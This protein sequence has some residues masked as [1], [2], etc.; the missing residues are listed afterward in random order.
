MG[1]SY[2]REIK[3]AYEPVLKTIAQCLGNL[4]Y[5][6][7]DNN[8]SME[9]VQRLKKSFSLLKKKQRTTLNY[10]YKT[11]NLISRLNLIDPNLFNSVNTI[12]DKR[13]NPIDIYVKVV[14][15][16]ESLTTL[17]FTNL[18]QSEEDNDIYY[19]QFGINTVYIEIVDCINNTFLRSDNL[20]L[21]VHELGHAMYQTKH[22][23]EYMSYYLKNYPANVNS[24]QPRGHNGTDPSGRMA[25]ET[26]TNFVKK[27]HEYYRKRANDLLLVDKN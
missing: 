19:S 7:S 5:L 20:I 23:D 4:E 21:F 22:L 3:N 12:R 13:G 26:V 1:K 17:A 10:F 27:Y 15:F 24:R 25:E 9:G 18:N 8:T 14:P 11:Q 6:L 2:G 16:N